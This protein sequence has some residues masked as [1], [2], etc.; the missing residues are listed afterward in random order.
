[1]IVILRDKDDMEDSKLAKD[2]YDYIVFEIL[3]YLYLI[4]PPKM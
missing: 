2:D 3:T 4:D 1:M